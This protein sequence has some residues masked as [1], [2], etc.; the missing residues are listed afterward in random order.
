[1]DTHVAI[2]RGLRDFPPE[3]RR[4]RM[5]A[6]SA[7]TISGKVVEGN[8]VPGKGLSSKKFIT[9]KRLVREEDRQVAELSIS[10]DGPYV[11][12]VC[13]ALDEKAKDGGISDYIIDDGSGDPLH[14]PNWGDTGWL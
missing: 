5:P 6:G 4:G 9:R 8:F 11:V 7:E 3:I 12:A 10:H 13:M 14:E 2:S 1:M